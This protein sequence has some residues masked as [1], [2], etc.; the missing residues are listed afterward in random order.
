MK[1]EMLGSLIAKVAIGIAT[2]ATLAGGTAVIHATE[3]NA[4][5]DVRIERVEKLTDQMQ[6]LNKTMAD[7]KTEVALLRKEMEKREQ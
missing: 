1:T 6:D 7:T 3:T 5:Q 2:A 4:V